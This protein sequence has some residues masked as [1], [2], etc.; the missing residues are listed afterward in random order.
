MQAFLDS[1]EC[2]NC[3]NTTKLVSSMGWGSSWYNL[4]ALAPLI[5][6]MHEKARSGRLQTLT[7]AECLREYGKMINP[8]RGSVLVV[9]ANVDYTPKNASFHAEEVYTVGNFD[10]EHVTTPSLALASYEW[11]CSGSAE[12]WR[13]AHWGSNGIET[14]CS[15][16]FDNIKE[17]SDA[18]KVG[19][20]RGEAPFESL[21]YNV[22]YCLSE[23]VPSHCKLQ[24]VPGI[25]ILVTI[26][27]F[28]K[29]VIIFYVAIGMK[30][31]PLMTMGDAVASFLE[32][33]DPT[34][35]NMCLLS[36]EDSRKQ[37]DYFPAGPR[38]W[39]EKTYRWKD[40]TSRTRRGVTISV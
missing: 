3:Q 16:F 32:K 35:K 9:A 11:V 20:P 26:L 38:E 37:D 2:V 29:A 25:M 15:D 6:T 36:I 27:N 17:H 19:F 7:N 5:E 8:Y 18:W 22:S 39:T 30:D 33:E 23:Q 21:T 40:V 28:F 13:D 24:F 1:P 14:H 4:T 10:P 31:E 12:W 34:T